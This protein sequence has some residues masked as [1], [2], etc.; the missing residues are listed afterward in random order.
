MYSPICRIVLRAY[1]TEHKPVEV[2][3]VPKDQWPMVATSYDLF[4]P[5]SK[6]RLTFNLKNALALTKKNI[7]NERSFPFPEEPDA[8]QVIDLD[9]RATP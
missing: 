8:S 2:E 4:L 7:P 5:E 9:A 3:G 1:L 6:S